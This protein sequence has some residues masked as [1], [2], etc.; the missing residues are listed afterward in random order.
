MCWFSTRHALNH[1]WFIMD[2]LNTILEEAQNSWLT[3]GIEP[4][5]SEEEAQ[6]ESKSDQESSGYDSLQSPDPNG[7]EWYAESELVQDE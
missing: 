3:D 7:G 1:K 2:K 5:P 6:S 4:T